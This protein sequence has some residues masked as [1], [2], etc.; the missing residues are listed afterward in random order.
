MLTV[1][2]VTALDSQLTTQLSRRPTQRLGPAHISD[3]TTGR[4][5][6]D[7]VSAVTPVRHCR[8]DSDVHRAEPGIGKG[9][10][11]VCT[12]AES[13]VGDREAFW[14]RGCAR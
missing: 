4:F 8:C 9:R 7:L 1:I 14:Y 11:Q 6:S 13:G 3:V 10:R 2:T 12:E 5:D